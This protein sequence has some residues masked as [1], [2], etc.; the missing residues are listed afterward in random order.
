MRRAATVP[1]S[2]AQARICIALRRA[3]EA[4]GLGE[5][6]DPALTA[7]VEARLATMCEPEPEPEPAVGWGE[8]LSET[9]ASAAVLFKI[10]GSWA[11]IA[12]VLR[13]IT[14]VPVD[15]S[16]TCRSIEY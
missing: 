8:W 10:G 7:A 5:C 16:L 2:A 6:L 13:P 4:E 3:V 11:I 14:H 9:A 1:R 12:P 15:V